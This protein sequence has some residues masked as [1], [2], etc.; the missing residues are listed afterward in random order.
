MHRFHQLTR[1]GAQFRYHQLCI[2]L[3]I[4]ANLRDT[5]N[6]APSLRPTRPT[7]AAL[8]VHRRGALV[9]ADGPAAAHQL[10]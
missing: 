7:A 2:G 4:I 1:L 6:G 10:A 9:A 3:R 5:T 8:R